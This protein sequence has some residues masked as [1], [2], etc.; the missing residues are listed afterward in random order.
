M[1]P[2]AQICAVDDMGCPEINIHASRADLVG[3]SRFVF[4]LLPGFSALDLGAGLES[5]AAANAAGAKPAFVWRIVSETG[6]PV[7]SS[8]RLTVAVDGALPSTQRGDYIVICG[9]LAERQHATQQ[10]IAWLRQ[11]A[12]F[13]ARLCGIGGG[14]ALLAQTGLTKG[15][16]LSAHWK[17]EHSLSEQY[18]NLDVVCSVFEE[19]LS[20]VTSAGGAATLDLF[21]ALIDRNCGSETASQVADQLLCGTI[22]SSSD[23]QTRSDLCRI[24][25]RHKKLGQ[26]IQLMRDHLE[27]PL[28]PSLVAE[29]VGLS[30]RQLERLFQR[31]LNTSPKTYMTTLRLDRARQLLQQTHMRVIEVAIACGFASASHF[32]K[33]YRKQFGISPHMERGVV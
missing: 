28:S 24:G 17:L 13:G 29:Q 5:L 31:Y 9:A 32:S 1:T 16:C 8:S 11:A 12:R 18:A 7:T 20:I 10:L 25:T 4:V 19:S 3:I 23:R 22:R 27:E 26:A 21:S 15:L 14:A 33:L 2:T 6:N 30:T